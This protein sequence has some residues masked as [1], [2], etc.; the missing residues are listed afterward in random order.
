[1]EV[2][3]KSIIDKAFLIAGITGIG[4]INSNTGTETDDALLTLN[5][6]LDSWKIDKLL[7]Y[8][9]ILAS[10]TIV[11]SPITIGPTGYIVN[12]RPARILDA[13]TQNFSNNNL[14]TPMKVIEYLTFDQI[15]LKT[16][17]STIP[18]YLY[19]EPTSPDGTIHIW[20][21]PATG[22]NLFVRYE[23]QISEF[24]TINDV[25]ELTP[26]YILGLQYTLASHLCTQYGLNRPDVELR[27]NKA[28][29]TIQRQ[30]VRINTLALDRRMPRGK[31]IFGSYNIDSGNYF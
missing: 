6:I 29:S 2:S 4:D 13:Y 27:A 12:Q 9:T 23:A 26:G 1:M 5:S 19:Y 3:A 8:D 25:I 22:L 28:V 20:P 16:V 11:D 10:G 31:R 30:N 18:I 7:Q 21:K 15:R 24:D 14:S 17:E